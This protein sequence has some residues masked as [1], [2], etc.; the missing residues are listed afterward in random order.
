MYGE[1][2]ITIFDYFRTLR[3]K[4]FVFEILIP[5]LL[6]FIIFLLV[7]NTNGKSS[8]RNYSDNAVSILGI[9]VGFSITII[10]LLT[11]SGSKNV[12]EIKNIKTDKILHGIPISLYQS[13]LINFTYSVIVEILLIL[14]HLTYPF[15]LGHFDVGD[16]MKSIFFSIAFAT[17]VHILLLNIRNLT[18]FY[19][20]LLK[21]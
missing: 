6:G 1:F 15:I 19:F 10:A 7:Y 13:L 18:N 11:T 21:K 14:V 16:L 17:L 8:I 5:A 3:K 9:L 20:V 4:N 2:L 12:E